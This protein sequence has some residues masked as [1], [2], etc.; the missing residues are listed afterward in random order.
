MRFRTLSVLLLVLAAAQIGSAQQPGTQAPAVGAA[1][2]ILS[3]E[4]SSNGTVTFRLAAP[5]ARQVSVVCECLTLEEAAKLEQQIAQLGQRSAGD[6]EIDRL[7][8]ALADVR[9]NQGVRAMTKGADGI[10]T[11]SLNGVA[12]DWYEYHFNVDGFRLLDPRNPIPKYNSRPNLIESLLQVSGPTP[13][14]WELKPVPHGAVSIQYYTSKATG[15]TRRVYIYTPP[16]YERSTARL[17]VLYLLH[18][19]DGDETLWTQY[20][21][22]NLIL[23]NQIAEK[24][25]APMIVVMP[26]AYAYPWYVGAPQEKQRADFEK[27]LLTDLIPFVDANYRTAADREHRALAGLSMGG[28]LTLMIGPRHLD[29]FSRIGMFS[30]SAGAD[31]ATSLKDLVANAQNV[32]SQLKVWWMGIGTQDPGYPNAKKSSDYLNSVGLKHSFHTMPGAHTWIVWRHF[33]NDFTPTLWGA[34]AATN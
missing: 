30:S 8:A 33:L 5:S 1:A 10:W 28:G 27:D 18:G 21:R 32:N 17:P 34:T 19:G 24:K 29:V 15:T 14:P 13:M 6:P 7:T 16:G 22:A 4:V 23:D 12:P 3:P 25:A 9:A 2:N 11:L 31:P 26:S 20:G